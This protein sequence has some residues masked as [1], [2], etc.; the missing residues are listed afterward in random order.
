[1]RR[2]WM[3]GVAVALAVAVMPATGAAQVPSDK[4]R[5]SRE[6][7]GKDWEKHTERIR[8]A[9]LERLGEEMELDEATRQKMAQSFD[10]IRDQFRAMYKERK[11]LSEKL[12]AALDREAP[13]VELEAILSEYDGVRN[14]GYR[15]MADRGTEVHQILG[16]RR[17]AKYVL[18]RKQFRRDIR[19]KLYERR[20][21]K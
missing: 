1:M 3:V 12:R 19:T 8:S 5:V 21:K 10:R 11:E 15:I 16:T 17:Y 9:F 4:G 14:R 2:S 13:D 20:Q 18:F 7:K 6:M